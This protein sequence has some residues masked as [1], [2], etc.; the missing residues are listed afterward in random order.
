MNVPKNLFYTDKHE[1]VAFE[2]DLAVIGITDHAQDSLGD[3]VFVSLPQTGDTL[4]A[5]DT[6]AELES[7]KAASAVYAPVGGTVAEVNEALIGAPEKVNEDPYGSWFVKLS[8]YE[9]N[10]QLLDAAAYEKLLAEEEA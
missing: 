7:V 5:G 10:D 1:W 8:G 9:K 2:G 4:A 6:A 3:I